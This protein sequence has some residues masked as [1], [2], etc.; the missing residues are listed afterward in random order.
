MSKLSYP[1]DADEPPGRSRDRGNRR[2][3]RA[4]SAAAL[5]ERID[6]SIRAL[7]RTPTWLAWLVLALCLVGTFPFDSSPRTVFGVPL[8]A[9]ATQWAA[10]LAILAITLAVMMGAL[11]AVRAVVGLIEEGRWIRRAPGIETDA[12][13]DIV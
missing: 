12:A 5:G 3:A 8:D 6:K 7:G 1:N 11:Y 9:R 13:A 10:Q 2:R 4:A